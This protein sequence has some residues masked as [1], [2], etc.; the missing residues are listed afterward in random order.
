M[1]RQKHQKQKILI[2]NDMLRAARGIDSALS[3]R[4]L[5][6]ALIEMDIP[7]D[8][9][10]LAAD[11]EVLAEYINNNDN[12]DYLLKCINYGKLNKYYSVDKENSTNVSF[13]RDEIK[14][15]ILGVNSLRLTEDTTQS[16]TDALKRKLIN[17]APEQDRERLLQYAEDNPY[18][19]DT[20][21]AKI[22][23][24]SINSLTFMR[25]T[26]SN[27]IIDTIIKL[28]DSDDRSAL[29]T[30]HNNPI[31]HRQ[32]DAGI[33]LYQIDHIFRA[34]D[35][36]TKLSFRY[37]DLD[38]NRNHILR[39]DGKEYIV[40]P[41]TLTPN[42]DHYYL[43]CYDSDTINKTRTYR[44][45]RMTNVKITDEPVSA[46]AKD[47]LKKLPKFTEQTFRMYSGPVKTV[48]LEFS[49]TLIGAVFDKFGS[50]AKIERVDEHLCRITEKI[51]L[52][53]PFLGWLF[54]FSKDML[55]ISPD[56]VIDE[57]CKHC[58]S[59]IQKNTTNNNG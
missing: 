57:Y 5:C 28:S 33:T 55:V 26:M 12:Y 35:S 45:D 39:H 11:F 9:R 10:T 47:F 32:N 3:T 30:E 50:G 58:E 14:T 37:F 53:P 18:L 21:A 19:F 44:I 23:I 54:Q 15:L 4:Q 56:D 48:T 36:K 25:G 2:I 52:S 22:L 13:N 40:E 17:A 51:Q 8:R 46:E 49:D 41:L 34:I 6:D 43:I 31:Y 24:D 42:D 20:I 16:D 27:Q 59:V 38:E 1:A 7:C 29:E